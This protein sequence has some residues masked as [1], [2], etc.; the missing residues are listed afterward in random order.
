[1]YFLQLELLYFIFQDKKQKNLKSDEV[2]QVCVLGLQI[3]VVF[4]LSSPRKPFYTLK[5]WLNE[6]IIDF[7]Y[8]PLCNCFTKAAYWMKSECYY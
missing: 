4:L 6:S 1:M 2:Y 7:V 8:T 3:P 5:I